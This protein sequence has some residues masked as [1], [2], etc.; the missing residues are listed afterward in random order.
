MEHLL[1]GVQG[2]R[3]QQAPARKG[4]QQNQLQ[5]YRP[6]TVTFSSERGLDVRTTK[7]LSAN[8]AKPKDKANSGRKQEAVTGTDRAVQTS[9]Q[10]PGPVK[11]QIRLLRQDQRLRI[12]TKEPVQK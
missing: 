6:A 5:Q 7:I 3:I 4:T 1:R 2:K 12:L 9:Q 11:S 8:R 10:R